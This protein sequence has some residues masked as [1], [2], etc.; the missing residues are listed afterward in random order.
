MITEIVLLYLPQMSRWMTQPP[1][2]AQAKS[3]DYLTL[4][5]LSSISKEQKSN[6]KFM[7]SMH[8]PSATECSSEGSIVS[9]PQ[10]PGGVVRGPTVHV[11]CEAQKTR[12]FRSVLCSFVHA[13]K[14]RDVYC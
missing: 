5:Q 10:R 9:P 13:L 11:R 12:R 8:D 6:T 4:V 14:H 1:L 7:P 3:R 2:E